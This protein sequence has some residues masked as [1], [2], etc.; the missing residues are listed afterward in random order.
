MSAEGKLCE[1]L[2]SKKQPMQQLFNSGWA[3]SLIQM[4]ILVSAWD[5]Q[6]DDVISFTSVWCFLLDRKVP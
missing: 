5:L 3:A 4:F 2:A 1:K 6:G